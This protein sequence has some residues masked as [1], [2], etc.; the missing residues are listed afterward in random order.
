MKTRF[1]LRFAGVVGA[2]AI[3]ATLTAG[4]AAAWPAGSKLDQAQSDASYTTINYDLPT[5]QTFTAGRSGWLVGI[6]VNVR[7]LEAPTAA[8][9]GAVP[10]AIA[11]VA[12]QIE[13]VSGGLPGGTILSSQSVAFSA[14]NGWRFVTL[15][16]PIAIVASTQYAIVLAAS[17]SAPI[18]WNG[19]CTAD[20][21]GGQA[22]V[23]NRGSWMDML[24]Y[25]AGTVCAN[26][27]A[28]R[29]YTGPGTTPPPT[30]VLSTAQGGDGSM[31]IEFAGL[32]LAALVGLGVAL[33]M[34]RRALATVR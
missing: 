15:P 4:G 31:P 17:G 3:L 6:E 18:G 21:A 30:S 19:T 9:A 28:F 22:L 32:A 23:Y 10:D 11:P 25:S 33:F 8:V 14:T 26:D 20:Y 24:A 34:T 1:G 12:V 7:G 29:T 5:A 2:V 27:F 13:D 16:K